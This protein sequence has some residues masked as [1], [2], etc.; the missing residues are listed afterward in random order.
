MGGGGGGG[1]SAGGGGG[2]SGGKKAGRDRV[3]QE[4]PKASAYLP[5]GSK[6]DSNQQ[7]TP[8]AAGAPK[9]NPNLFKTDDEAAKFLKEE[10]GVPTV[11]LAS[12]KAEGAVKDVASILPKG[13]K[14]LGTGAEA[15][16]IDIGG[17]KMLRVQYNGLTPIKTYDI[18][19]K[20]AYFDWQAHYGPKGKGV[21]VSQKPMTKF[22]AY[23][24]SKADR[25]IGF[26]QIMDTV[27]TYQ[28]DKYSGKGQK[29]VDKDMKFNA[30][31]WG[32]DVIGGKKVW[33]VTDP[34]ALLPKGDDTVLAEA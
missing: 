1:G 20:G 26:K 25:E 21:Y 33:R 9:P 32:F 12:I 2:A 19:P 23:E 8:P 15:I 11:Q 22:M 17:G 31:N 27:K 10:V 14:Y 13:S 7:V 24:A 34:G 28:G 3:K 29:F 16:G 4:S 18:G 30:S 5:E 6:V